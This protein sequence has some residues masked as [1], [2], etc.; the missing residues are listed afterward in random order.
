MAV[1]SLEKFDEIQW[2]SMKLWKI[3][4]FQK[5]R[6]LTFVEF[7]GEKFDKMLRN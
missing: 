1:E 7:E 2:N 5:F 4:Q 3:V 6:Q